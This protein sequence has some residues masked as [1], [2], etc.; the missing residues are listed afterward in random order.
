VK[1][2]AAFSMLAGVWMEYSSAKFAIE[3]VEL[4]CRSDPTVLPLKPVRIYPSHLKACL[5]NLEIT[6]TQR[7]FSEFEAILRQYWAVLKRGKTRRTLTETLI[8][9]LSAALVISDIIR[10]QTHAVREYRNQLTHHA[11]NV[12]AIPLSETIGRLN[13]FLKFFPPQW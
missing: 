2:Q 9:R 10:V 13:R 6:Y 5:R 12:N 7:M 1:R 8:H 3:R 4:E 11:R